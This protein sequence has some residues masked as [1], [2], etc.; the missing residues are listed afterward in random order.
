MREV[1]NNE[2]KEISE[3]IVKKM[4]ESTNDYDAIEDVAYMVRN[5]LKGMKVPVE[6]HKNNSE[7]KCKDCGCEK[8]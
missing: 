7:C 2:I 6:N 3:D 5:M 4:N 1:T 8:E